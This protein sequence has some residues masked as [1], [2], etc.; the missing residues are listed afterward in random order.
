MR[1][2]SVADTI[3]AAPSAVWNVLADFPNISDWNGGVTASH[4]TGDATGGVGATRH[5]DLGGAAL[6]TGVSS[7]ET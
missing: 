1:T 2:I 6:N 7:D 3:D 5:C 4:A